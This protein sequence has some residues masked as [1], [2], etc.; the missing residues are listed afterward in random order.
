[1]VLTSVFLNLIISMLLFIYK[2][3]QNK[4][5]IYLVSLILLANMRQ[6]I[7]LL[8]NQPF[9]SRVLAVLLVHFDPVV[10]LIGPLLFLYFKSLTQGKFVFEKWFW[11][12]LI[13]V[14]IFFIN[15]FS[16][17]FL[18]FESKDQFAK[19]MQNN[20]HAYVKLP[21]GTWLFDYNIQMIIAPLHNWTFII[22]SFIY[23]YQQKKK[24]S[25]KLKISRII[26]RLKW[27]IFLMM[28]PVLLQI[29]FATLKS[30]KKFDL[31]FQDSTINFDI[32]YLSTLF[33]PLSFILF[34]SLLY[35]STST[36]TSLWEK[37]KELW[38]SISRIALDEKMENTE[39]S[40]DLDRIIQY[41]DKKKPYL[42]SNFSVH[43]VSRELNIPHLRVSNSFNKQ[44]K[45]PF[46][47]YRNDFRVKYAVQM[48]KDQKHLEMSIEGIAMQSGF[49]TKSAFYAAFKSEYKMT[50]TEWIEKNL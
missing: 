36:S 10:I 44:I 38:V 35:G 43:V 27:I 22:Y 24:K 19:L 11:I 28:L 18:D 12:Y 45:I 5:I 34:P 49:K 3:R 15:T 14:S 30:P 8:L 6:I 42:K 1:M 13:P 16:Y 31:S 29:L 20:N 46:P 40:T 21:G 26:V 47:K 23:V 41:M 39:K 17:Y 48:F 7:M 50:P 9:E 33:L 2:W 4:A 25:I 32:M 37:V